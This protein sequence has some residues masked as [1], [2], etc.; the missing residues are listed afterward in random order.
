M[1]QDFRVSCCPSGLISEQNN[2]IK[3]LDCTVRDGGI[4]N[5]W[6]FDVE[7][8]QK[9]YSALSDS[10]ID[11]MEIGYQTKPGLFDPNEVGLWR[12]CEESALKQVIQNSQS[13]MKLSTMVDVG[14]F[15]KQDL[16]NAQD[17]SIDVL[18][19]ATYAHQMDAAL[20]LLN[21]ALNKGYETF[22]NVMA[23][24]TLTPD[25]VD[26]FLKQ[27]SSSGVNNVAIVDSFGAMYPYHIRYLVQK[28]RSILG[29][30]I[31]LGVHCHNNQ[32]QAFANSIAAAD[33]GVD[34]IDA[35]I[36]GMGRGAGNC[37][38]ELL[39]FYLN[40]PNHTI[41]PIL[42]LTEYFV[43]LRYDLLWGYHMPYAITGYLNLHP[44]AAIEQMASENRAEVVEL[45]HRLASR[46][47]MKK[48]S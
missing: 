25:K 6:D 37:P 4:C 9:I 24:S 2:R 38:L 14:R 41:E 36:F 3:V 1:D 39:L 29:S 19:I 20:D 31:G 5:D 34:F 43:K 12:F 17:S 48:S 10:G 27:L 40:N 18:R 15:R 16:P 22:I 32:Q 13:K 28:Y 44:R 46:L 11:Y 21:D 42:E 33:E 47:K 7:T 30:N 26:V 23:V 45:Y 8:V 35:T